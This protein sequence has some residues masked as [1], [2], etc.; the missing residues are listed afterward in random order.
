[1]PTSWAGV[2]I[3]LSPAQE[4]DLL[5]EGFYVNIHTTAFPGGEIR[6][7]I[8][9]PTNFRSSPEGALEVPPVTTTA[10]ATATFSLDPST[11]ILSYDVEAFSLSAPAT[12]A[13][14]HDAPAGA[15]GGIVFSLVS[16]GATTWAGTTAP[17]STAQKIDLLTKGFYLNI[18]NGSFPGGEIRDQLHVGSLNTDNPG[19]S[20]SNGCSQRL[21]LD[22]GP[23][24]AGAT[25]WV[26]GTLSGTT[27]GVVAPGGILV[28]VNPDFYFDHTIDNPNQPPMTLSLAT[29]DANGQATCTFTF[30]AGAFPTLAGMTMHH[31]FALI[32]FGAGSAT[33]ASNAVP[34]DLFP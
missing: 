2:T 3:M 8:V 4:T 11:G 9:A 29:L 6:G 7:Q 20:V 14:I 25:Y 32:D 21:F 33:F 15:P 19:L 5:R 34:L 10:A 28:P 13:H 12:S 18:H 31:A 22:A 23:A 1:G 16:T 26:V 17:L 30:P 24:N 27:P